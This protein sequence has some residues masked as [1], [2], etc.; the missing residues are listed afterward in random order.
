MVSWLVATAQIMTA[1]Q[2]QVGWL[3]SGRWLA[4]GSGCNSPP[5]APAGCTPRTRCPGWASTAGMARGSGRPGSSPTQCWSPRTR[6]LS[7]PAPQPLSPAPRH[8]GTPTGQR[9]RCSPPCSS[10][11]SSSQGVGRAIAAGAA[12]PSRCFSN[13]GT[14]AV[15]CSGTVTPVTRPS[16][17][18][19]AGTVQ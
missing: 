16:Q 13:S 8:P 12:A 3:I 1:P 17:S 6:S 5:G 19:I 4:G 15:G 7:S 18:C 14:A 2:T 10:S 9:S 11:S